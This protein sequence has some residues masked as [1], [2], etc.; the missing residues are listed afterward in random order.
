MYLVDLRLEAS[1]I[2][3]LVGGLESHAVK[4]VWLKGANDSHVVMWVPGKD[5]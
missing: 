2:L 5:L 4:N 3:S 1:E